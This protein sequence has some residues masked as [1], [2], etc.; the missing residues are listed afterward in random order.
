[1]TVV[2]TIAFA[3]AAGL[4]EQ[5]IARRLERRFPAVSYVLIDARSGATVAVNRNDANKPIPAGSLVKPFVAMTAAT[6]GE[7]FE[8]RAG[9]CWLPQGHGRV[10]LPQAIAHSCNRYF[11]RLAETAGVDAVSAAAAR[12]GFPPPARASS[13]GALIGLRG[14]WQASPLQIAQAYAALLRSPDSAGIREG[15]RLSAR[16]GTARR[17]GVEALA[18]T[19]TA[20][21]SHTRRGMGDGF[22]IAAYPAKS[23]RYVLLIRLHNTTGANAAATAGEILRVIR[24]AS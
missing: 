11:L 5:S 12:F 3:A 17:I 20:R 16:V 7:P 6:R 13:A 23:P 21:C 9:E 4:F 10:D 24:D 15:L 19:G 1:M 8:C 22:V 2:L 18:K 14:E